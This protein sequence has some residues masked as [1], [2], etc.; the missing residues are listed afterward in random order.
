MPLGVLRCICVLSFKAL[1][2]R[3]R[4]REEGFWSHLRETDDD[5]SSVS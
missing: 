3:S 1:L 4:W 2:K 5:Y